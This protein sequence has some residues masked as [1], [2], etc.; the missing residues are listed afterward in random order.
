MGGSPLN[1]KCRARALNPAT[2]FGLSTV[3]SA[4]S[5]VHEDCLSRVTFCAN[6]DY[7]TV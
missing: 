6:R 3:E 5:G 2:Y 7:E 1:R 4:K